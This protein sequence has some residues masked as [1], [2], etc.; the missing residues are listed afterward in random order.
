MGR[1]LSGSWHGAW[2]GGAWHDACMG[3]G[4]GNVDDVVGGGINVVLYY[5]NPTPTQPRV[6]GLHDTAARSCSFLTYTNCCIM[7]PILF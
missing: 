1:C 6:T 3:G 2:G 7:C 4:G 5:P